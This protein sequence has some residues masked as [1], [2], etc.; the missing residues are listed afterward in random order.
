[1][2]PGGQYGS[3]FGCIRQYLPR[4]DHDTPVTP[5]SSAGSMTVKQAFNRSSSVILALGLDVVS[6][7]WAH[8]ENHIAV[9]SNA[10]HFP[11]VAFAQKKYPKKS[12]YLSLPAGIDVIQ[13]SADGF[14]VLCS[15]AT[16]KENQ[17]CHK[18]NIFH[19]IFNNPKIRIKSLT[20]LVTDMNPY[21][22]PIQVNCRQSRE[23]WKN[24]LDCGWLA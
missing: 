18:G 10:Y 15:C 4:L 20:E 19:L 8:L 23:K 1:M 12:S 2:R 14:H 3:R 6:V 5:G 16:S 13:N 7:R 17:H 22:S 24:L 11:Q 21:Q 9:T